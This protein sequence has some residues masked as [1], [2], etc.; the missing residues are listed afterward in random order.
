MTRADLPS[1]SDFDASM[2]NVYD[3]RE[4]ANRMLF[5]ADAI[6]HEIERRARVV[7][8]DREPGFKRFKVSGLEDVMPFCETPRSALAWALS[9]SYLP[10]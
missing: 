6:E 4:A 3:I 10:E 7:E 2:K 9:L 5:T 8:F 1:L